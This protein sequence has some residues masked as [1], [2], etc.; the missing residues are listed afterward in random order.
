[1]NEIIKRLEKHLNWIKQSS[2]YD[3][4]AYHGPAYGDLAHSNVDDVLALVE[5]FK[6]Q[7]GDRKV[8]IKLAGAFIGAEVGN[9]TVQEKADY[10]LQGLQ[11]VRSALLTESVPPTDNKLSISGLFGNSG[12]PMSDEALEFL[13]GRVAEAQRICKQE[14]RVS[15]K[16]LELVFSGHLRGCHDVE[17]FYKDGTS[18][19][20]DA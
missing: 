14:S 1:M 15:R 12:K 17:E 9:H 10:Y 3:A 2:W 5:A 20:E 16:T 19:S 18:E 7:R 4:A 6:A 11:Q 8:V 13:K